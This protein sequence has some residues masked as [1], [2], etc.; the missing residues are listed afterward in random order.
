[1]N[2]PTAQAIQYSISF[3]DKE[4][5]QSSNKIYGFIEKL[6]QLMDSFA[7]KAVATKNKVM[8]VA[9]A[10]AAGMQRIHESFRS[11]MMKL[12][13]PVRWIQ[14][15]FMK[16]LRQMEKSYLFF[17]NTLVKIDRFWFKIKNNTL[18]YIR[19]LISGTDEKK[20]HLKLL[21]EQESRWNRILNKAKEYKSTI[22]SAV[23]G[24]TAIAGGVSASRE[25]A[26]LGGLR[27][28]GISP[29][30]I[31][32][33]PKI[34][35]E[36][37]RELS[38]KMD[39]AISR[40]EVGQAISA[41]AI[42]GIKEIE[43][44]DYARQVIEYSKALDISIDESAET[45]NNFRRRLKMTSPE[46]TKFAAEM[47][48]FGEV[49]Q[50]SGAQLSKEVDTAISLAETLLIPI[51]N[52]KRFVQEYMASI[53]AMDKSNVGSEVASKL[54][55]G[56]R[57]GWLTQDQNLKQ[58]AAFSGIDADT[59]MES[60]KS[61][62][63]T[64]FYDAFFK[65]LE[66][67]PTDNM[68]LFNA[69]F[70][71]DYR[72]ITDQIRKQPVDFFGPLEKAKNTKE[73]FFN[74][75]T[76]DKL[77]Q[78]KGIFIN[79]WE[80][81]KRRFRPI[82]EK[83]VAGL[84]KVAIGIE[85]IWNMLGPKIQSFAIYGGI[86]LGSLGAVKTALLFI[87]GILFKAVMLPLKLV[88]S[89][90]VGS[91]FGHLKKMVLLPV[92]EWFMG[93]GTSA[94][95]AGSWIGMAFRTISDVVTKI[96]G[97]GLLKT[98]WG[99][100]SREFPEAAA[101]ISSKATGLATRLAVVVGIIVTLFTWVKKFKEIGGFSSLGKLFSFD[102]GPAEKL[103]SYFEFFAKLYDSMPK[104]L[105]IATFGLSF[106]LLLAKRILNDPRLSGILERIDNIWVGM[107]A[108]FRDAMDALK[109]TLQNTWTAIT[110]WLKEN[111]IGPIAGFAVKVLEP[112]NSLIQTIKTAIIGAWTTLKEDIAGI[113]KWLDEK[114]LGSQVSK[115]FKEA[116]SFL[117]MFKRFEERGKAEK[118]KPS[119]SNIE[120]GSGTR[121]TSPAPVLPPSPSNNMV[122]ASRGGIDKYNDAIAMASEKYGVDKN[123][124]RAII[125]SE[126]AGN[127]NA[128]SPAGA[129]G[130]MQLMPG[131]ASDMGLSP[132]ERFDPNKNVDAGTKY[133]SRMLERYNGDVALAL[134]AYNAGPG[135]V[136]GGRIP[137]NGETPN[138]VRSVLSNYEKFSAA[139]SVSGIPA[140]TQVASNNS[141]IPAQST[142][143]KIILNQ[144]QVVKELQKIAIIL[145]RPDDESKV[146]SPV[147]SMRTPNTALIGEI[148]SSGL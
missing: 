33:I 49:A 71:E 16:F 89:L 12:M 41:G 138:Y 7:K 91:I 85:K 141:N 67:A 14:N 82:V 114:I 102:T 108:S 116:T 47:Q 20:R 39:I 66:N 58:I 69:I 113:L 148:A 88:G 96:A 107:K 118:G 103:K 106:P 73:P 30:F 65:A 144:D 119:F 110:N 25:L 24:S 104:L 8:E 105:K 78:I 18:S 29:D 61:G 93:I 27:R 80:D 136:R 38:R 83:M 35:T 109:G 92:A 79:I 127:P 131:T 122:M 123:L 121:S 43:L 124:I 94:R 50:M 142:E 87:G 48:V 60:V 129:G 56:F 77:K 13:E 133:F 32:Q 62:N 54:A 130:L 63:L 75:N 36:L 134:A 52:Q 45:V 70:G 51:E 6:K 147:G 59:L 125:K 132:G 120:S 115:F 68:Q 111:V 128:V 84:L 55:E 72:K 4:A 2:G 64:Q 19:S 98:L 90:L 76:I 23:V 10:V 37:S 17:S 46:I 112:I 126:S 44:P 145:Q 15:Q 74:T 81:V 1:M 139:D 34:A 97:Q 117:D 86:I 40:S 31:K 101:N 140:S 57:S 143:E 135:N 3:D 26:N 21:E 100:L 42:K 146:N 11:R 53:A 9:A 22:A 137:E 28:E 99:F 5:R 95:F